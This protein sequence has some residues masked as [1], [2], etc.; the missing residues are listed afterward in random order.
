MLSPTQMPFIPLIFFLIYSPITLLLHLFSC[1]NVL[2]PLHPL[3]SSIFDVPGVYFSIAPSFL[4]CFSMSFS[5]FCSYCSY[6]FSILFFHPLSSTSFLNLLFTSPCFHFPLCFL[7]SF[8]FSSIEFLLFSQLALIYYPL[9]SPSFLPHPLLF[10]LFI[11]FIL[12]SIMFIHAVIFA[13]SSLF[14]ILLFAILAE[15]LQAPQTAVPTHSKNLGEQLLWRSLAEPS[16]PGS[17]HPTFHRE[18]CRLHRA[19]R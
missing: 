6:C 19:H 11:D 9:F 3:S 1:D 16:N 13:I 7:F 18:M 12:H 5:R 10:F 15:I 8:L 2:P 4:Y 14:F 17:P